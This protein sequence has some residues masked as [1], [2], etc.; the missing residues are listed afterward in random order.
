MRQEVLINAAWS[1]TAHLAER[2]PKFDARYPVT[3]SSQLV[4][5]IVPRFD[6]GYV[7]KKLHEEDEHHCIEERLEI[8]P[9]HLIIHNV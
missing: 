1:N 8:G 4:N 3:E 6:R 5:I 9:R 7:Q 2:P